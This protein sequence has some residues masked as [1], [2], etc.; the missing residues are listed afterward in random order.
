MPMKRRL[1]RKNLE[2]LFKQWPQAVSADAGDFRVLH[3]LA[4]AGAQGWGESLNKP[5][6]IWLGFESDCGNEGNGIATTRS[7]SVESPNGNGEQAAL[8]TITEVSGDAL[9]KAGN[10]TVSQNAECILEVKVLEANLAKKLSGFR[11]AIPWPRYLRKKLDHTFSKH[12]R[13]ANK[14][15]RDAKRVLGFVEA[16]GVVVFLNEGAPTIDRDLIC[17]YLAKAIE[18]LEY[19]DAAL[20]L[21]DSIEKP[22]PVPLVTKGPTGISLKK[23]HREFMMMMSSFNWDAGKP[24]PRGFEPINLLAQISL[25]SR[26]FQMYKDWATGWRA[27]DDPSPIPSPSL[28]IGYVPEADYRSTVNTNA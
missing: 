5:D 25:D 2:S 3:D 4:N 20:Y 1:T 17:A 26:S 18:P 19:I 11:P 27:A 28:R 24:V 10:Y 14:Q 21:A 8:G 7:V 16:K 12:L 15:I 13:Q 23:F 9:P 22:A 6:Y